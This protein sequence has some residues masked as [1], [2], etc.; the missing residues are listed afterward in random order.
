VVWRLG[1]R[2]GGAFSQHLLDGVSGDEVDQQ[3]T[4]ETTKPDD[5]RV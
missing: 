3:E 4:V 1:C 2:R 5:G